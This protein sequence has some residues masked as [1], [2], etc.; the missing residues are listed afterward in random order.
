[1]TGLLCVA[2]HD[3]AP[4]NWVACQR[5]LQ[6]VREVADVP[7]SLLAV[8][9]HHLRGSDPQMEA[10]LSHLLARGH[11]LVLHGY[12]HLDPGEPRN[13]WDHLKR[14]V[15]T[16]GEGEFC[17][18]G[19]AEARSRIE[20]GARWFAGRGWPLHGFVAPA[21]LLSQGSWQALRDSPL[22]YTTTLSGVHALQTGASLP[23]EAMVF[24]TRSRWRRVASL[25]RNAWVAHTWRQQRLV[26]FELHPHD[27]DHPRIR[28]L[29]MRELAALSTQ[30]QAVTLAQAVESLW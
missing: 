14:R 18:L 11:E 25:A 13:Q 5:V 24:S 12:S 1:M 19:R 27:A 20:A 23:C 26:R 21:W 3:V 7:L 10:A 4:V 28:Q 29:W 22:R 16:D 9:H 2:I 8:P 17:D 30:R 15:Y 6:A